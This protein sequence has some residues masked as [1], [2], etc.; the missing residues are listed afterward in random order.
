VWG[1]DSDGDM[2]GDDE[3]THVLNSLKNSGIR[4]LQQVRI[5]LEC[6]LMAGWRC[7]RLGP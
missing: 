2:E 5:L 3:M 6:K 4:I 7:T 1:A